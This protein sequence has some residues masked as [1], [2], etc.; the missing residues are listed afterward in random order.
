MAIIT[1]ITDDIPDEQVSPG[2]LARPST[3]TGAHHFQ[4]LKI[5]FVLCAGRGR[6]GDK[7]SLRRGRIGSMHGWRPDLVVEQNLGERRQ[8]FSRCRGLHWREEGVC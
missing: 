3:A 2:H 6:A 5:V 7:K 4:S 8:K 1:I